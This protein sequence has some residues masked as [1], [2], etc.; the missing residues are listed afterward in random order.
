MTLF[1]LTSDLRALDELLEERDGDITDPEVERAVTNWFAELSSNEGAKLDCY[2]G[3]I[4]TL[5][6]EASAARAEAEQYEAKAKTREKRVAWLKDRVKLHLE[7]TH[8]AKVETATKRVI[9]I[10]PNGGMAPLLMAD[11]L[12]PAALPDEYVRVK[13]E[14]DREAIRRALADG[15]VLPFARLGEK[16]THLR[17]R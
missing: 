13:R 12:D 11:P 1:E 14:P 17:I 2:V 6:M 3:Y 7:Q 10:Q 5:E 4:R 8:R 16:G 15:A 9:A